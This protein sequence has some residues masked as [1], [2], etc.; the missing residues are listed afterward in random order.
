MVQY[1]GSAIF[2]TWFLVILTELDNSIVESL[3]VFSF[4]WFST[5]GEH[6]EESATRAVQTTIKDSIWRILWSFTYFPSNCEPNKKKVIKSL[7]KQSELNRT[8]TRW[9]QS[10]YSFN[11]PFKSLCVCDKNICEQRIEF[12][13]DRNDQNRNDNF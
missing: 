8:F 5:K 1:A 2:T 6:P 7:G 10:G 4:I 3:A 11:Q 13:Y 12:T 9:T